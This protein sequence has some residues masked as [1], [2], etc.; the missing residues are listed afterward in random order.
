MVLVLVHV[1][2]LIVVVILVLVLVLVIVLA[3]VLPVVL[4]MILDLTLILIRALAIS[5]VPARLDAGLGFCVGGWHIVRKVSVCL[6]KN[7]ALTPRFQLLEI[8]SK[9]SRAGCECSNRFIPETEP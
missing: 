1:L 9:S 4:N 2:V 8:T 6:P 5:V 7:Q 3:L